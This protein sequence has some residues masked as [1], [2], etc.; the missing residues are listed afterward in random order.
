MQL[1]PREK[2]LIRISLRTLAHMHGAGVGPELALELE[3]IATKIKTDSRE[4][5][6][7]AEIGGVYD[8]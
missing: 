6:E 4:A 3:S 5:Q 2:L 7:W 8:N 1:T